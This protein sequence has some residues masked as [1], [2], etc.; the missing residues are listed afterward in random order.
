MARLVGF[1]FHSIRGR[2]ITGVLLLHAV[3]MGLVVLDMMIRQKEF[4]ELQLAGKGTAMVEALAINA[5]SWMLSSDLSG[6]NELTD[7]FKRDTDLSVSLI[8]DRQGKVRASSDDS[9]FNLTLDDAETMRLLEMQKASGKARSVYRWHDGVVDCL[10]PIV[11]GTV[12]IGY[13]RVVLSAASVS[14]EL[15]QVL[16]KGGLYTVAAI[17]L[18]GLL[19]WLLVRTMTGR[20]A[21]LSHA[22]DAIAGGN[23]GVSLPDDEAGRDEVA[24]LIR[25]F[26]A[27]A[28]ALE[29]DRGAQEALMKRLDAANDDLFRLTEVS[30]HHLQ[31]PV[32]RLVSF[33]Q[34]LRGLVQA[35]SEPE[36]IEPTLAQIDDD[37]RYLR[38]LLN[39][40]QAYLAIIHVVPSHGSA[41]PQAD[42]RAVVEE[43][44][45]GL[46]SAI[47]QA[48]AEV[49]VGALPPVAMASG[50]LSQVFRQIIDNGLKFRRP[51]LAPRI[52]ISAEDVGGRVRL[53]ITD[54]GIGVP[55]AMRERVFRIFERLHPRSTYA[56]TGIGLAM[57]RRIVENAGGTVWLEEPPGGG[58]LVGI[59]LPA[60]GGDETEG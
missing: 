29:R 5:T 33:S 48:G 18:G 10:A 28:R 3:L 8:L 37:G 14:A 27:M 49:I 53:R 46:Q 41:P 25:D 21:T 23:L 52:G 13:A 6:L 38:S 2:L 11:A 44:C 60:G 40:I 31:E 19:A 51:D 17:A 35:R 45:R 16:L 4:M 43:V 1:V 58:T 12:E 57:V 9:L 7:G 36:V 20:L 47:A 54:N 24:R 34:R 15:D 42:T 22:A 30:A 39:D 50:Q 26:N 56:G 32:R 59:E 55:V